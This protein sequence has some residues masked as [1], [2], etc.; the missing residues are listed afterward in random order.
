MWNLAQALRLIRTAQPEIHELGYH[1][2][3]GGSILNKGSSKDDLDLFILRKNNTDR[4]DSY[5]VIDQMSKIL[6]R[7]GEIQTRAM[8]DSP[9]YGPDADFHFSEAYVFE[10]DGKR[11]DVFVQ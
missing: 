10:L 2:T 5:V 6:G 3:L 9:D 1:I 11:I 4:V 8:R 7:S